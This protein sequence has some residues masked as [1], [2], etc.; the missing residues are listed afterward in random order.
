MIT[1]EATYE[2]L[3]KPLMN[4]TTLHIDHATPNKVAKLWYEPEV[5]AGGTTDITVRMV[6]LYGNVVDSKREDALKIPSGA[7]NVTFIVGSSGGGAAFVDGTDEITVPVDENGNATATLQV[8]TLVGENLVY[9]KS[10]VGFN[11]ITI[12]SVAG[13]PSTITPV[14]DPRDASV[15]ADGEKMISLTY[16][17]RDRYGNLAVGQGLWVNASVG[18]SDRQQTLL[19]STH[20][21]QVAITY[22]PEGSACDVI[23][24]ATAVAAPTVTDVTNLLF[25]DPGPAKMLLSASP[26]S[27]PSRDVNEGSVSEIRA[28]VMDIGGNPVEGETVKFVIISNN[29]A[30]YNQTVDQKLEW[31]SATTDRDGYAVVKFYPGSFAPPG[32]PGWNASAKGT[33]TV[34]ATWENETL[35]RSATQNITLTW[36]NYP[37]LS[38]ET[39]VSPQTVTVNDTVDVTIQL[40]GGGWKMEQGGLPIDVV[41]CLDRGEDMLLR[42]K[43]DSPSSSGPD[44]M[45]YAREA[46]AN[47]TANISGFG[48]TNR[49][50]LV[51][52]G[53]KPT[54]ETYPGG[55]INISGL[56]SSYSNWVNNVGEDGNGN[57]DEDYVQDHYPGNGRIWYTDYAEVWSSL[58]S[59]NSLVINNSLWDIVPIKDD[60]RGTTS[61]PLRKGLHT[62]IKELAGKSRPNTVKAIVVLMQNDYCYYGD[63]LARG[64][65]LQDPVSITNKNLKDY[66][67]FF[68]PDSPKEKE[69][70]AI[71]AKDNGIIIYTIYYAWGASPGQKGVPLELANQ[72]GGQFIPAQNAIELNSALG[73]IAEDLKRHAGVDTKVDLNF[74][75]VWVSNATSQDSDEGNSHTYHGSDVFDYVYEKDVSTLIQSY[76]STGNIFM[77]PR[78]DT[79]AWDANQTLHF[80][81][82]TIELDQ[83]WK[84][85]FRLRVK[86]DGNINITGS[87]ST[88]TFN[89]GTEILNFPDT[90]ITA[91]PQDRSVTTS[92]LLAVVL[93]RPEP[94]AGQNAFHDTVPLT[95]T[96][97]YNGTMDVAESLAYSKNNGPPWNVFWKKTLP[98]ETIESMDRVDGM[99]RVEDSTLM[100]VRGLPPGEYWIQVTASADDAP[101]A[102]DRTDAPIRIGNASAAYIKIA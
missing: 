49:V 47:F 51:V 36:V 69:S 53:D 35:G 33:A 72:T 75:R 77:Y 4:I 32:M 25:Y 5:T 46:V 12:F 57:D 15:R 6:D 102:V 28:K 20:R 61:A 76:D 10:P 68:G 31:G 3:D 24:T 87:A 52:Y 14:V 89:D 73:A 43:S 19:Y 23:I 97:T 83:T 54:D 34:R 90:F 18:Q 60:P 30:P 66:Y 1:A 29:S 45:E 27:M 91:I 11:Y 42:D 82:G 55:V 70:M 71:Y 101:E 59:G 8:D 79:A 62:S 13:P 56:G 81:I 67:A 41:F 50:G 88:I 84:A 86:T 93:N 39:S 7:E 44:R 65:T 80:D 21:G 37:Y 17:L 2:G 64:E 98:Y 63:P 95:W 94:P 58:A 100:D 9:I 26:L 16:T 38:V 40:K 22:G 78:D 48:E 85:T 96:L 74:K 99:S 92:R